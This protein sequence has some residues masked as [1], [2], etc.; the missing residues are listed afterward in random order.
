[1]QITP[2]F[3]LHE[4]RFRKGDPYHHEAPH[5]AVLHLASFH[6]LAG[7]GA[8]KRRRDMAWAASLPTHAARFWALSGST[9]DSVSVM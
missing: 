4:V 1:M 9:R 7:V 2:R 8:R 3:R 6:L 5:V